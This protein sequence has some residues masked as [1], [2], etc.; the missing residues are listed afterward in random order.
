[1][2]ESN[3]T[4]PALVSPRG[5]VEVDPPNNITLNA[6][7]SINFTCS[8]MGGPNNMFMW[9]KN[10][11]NIVCSNCSENPTPQLNLTG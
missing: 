10:G 3:S 9:L 2:T 6:G 4:F 11:T 7:E 8:A 1:M 5:S